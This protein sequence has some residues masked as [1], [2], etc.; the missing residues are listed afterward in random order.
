MIKF[1]LSLLAITLFAFSVLSHATNNTVVEW[2]PFV[3]VASASDQELI[4]AASQV[5]AGFL[6]LQPGFIKRELVKKS[7]TEYADIVYWDSQKNAQAAGSKVESC[8]VCMGYFQL[9]DM[10]AS[11][12]SGA[13]FSYYS[14]IKTW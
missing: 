5:N 4:A 12:T 1:K 7:D 10:K 14:I 2:A 11:E 3:K 13:G 9:M 8:T 6:A